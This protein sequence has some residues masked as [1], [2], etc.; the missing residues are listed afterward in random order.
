MCPLRR[1]GLVGLKGRPGRDRI[2]TVHF[3][4]VR[5]EAPQYKYVETFIDEGE[6]DMLACMRAF[7]EVGYT[8]ML[9][10]DHTPGVSGDTADTRVG[11][12]FAIGQM[13]AMRH[14]VE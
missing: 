6:C 4:N 12:A 10:P 14:A 9:D 11:W 7:K 8:G 1:R 3:R 2:G 13:I 5:V